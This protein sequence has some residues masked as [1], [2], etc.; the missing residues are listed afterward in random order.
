MSNWYHPPCLDSSS[1][2]SDEKDGPFIYQYGGGGG[3]ASHQTS[4]TKDDASS[5]KK[6]LVFIQEPSTIPAFPDSLVLDNN[7]NL[8][9]YKVFLLARLVIQKAGARTNNTYYV[10]PRRIGYDGSFPRH[11]YFCGWRRR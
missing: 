4:S 3:G 1:V 2:G 9:K 8:T 7:R 10:L 5:L 11:S 6:Q